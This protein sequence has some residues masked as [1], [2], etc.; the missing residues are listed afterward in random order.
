MLSNTISPSKPF[1]LLINNFSLLQKCQISLLHINNNIIQS[2]EV[3]LNATPMIR[4]MVSKHIPTPHWQLASFSLLMP[5]DK[6]YYR[7][8]NVHQ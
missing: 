6:L 7:K 4:T 1:N 8:M 2:T 3:R 5:S